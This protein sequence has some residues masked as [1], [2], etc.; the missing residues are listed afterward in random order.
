M[1][2]FKPLA[3]DI[4]HYK[5]AMYLRSGDHSYEYLW[6]AATRCLHMKRED[7]MQGSVSRD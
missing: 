3:E 5:R 6:D 4:A 1:Q 2:Y 7:H